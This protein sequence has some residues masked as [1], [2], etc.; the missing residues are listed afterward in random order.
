M[1]THN[2]VRT[3]TEPS[4][5]MAAQLLSLDP[6]NSVCASSPKDFQILT[7]HYSTGAPSRVIDSQSK[8]D[9]EHVSDDV[10]NAHPSFTSTHFS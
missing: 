8:T 2:T 6:Q 9:P 3:Q 1:C 5:D 4:P 10:S 7:P